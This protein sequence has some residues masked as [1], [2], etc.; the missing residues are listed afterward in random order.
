VTTDKQRLNRTPLPDLNGLALGEPFENSNL[1]NPAIWG[2]YLVAP[3][4]ALILDKMKREITKEQQIYVDWLNSL[5]WSF[6]TTLTTKYDLN[7]KTGRRSAERFFGILS[8]LSDGCCKMF[9]VVEPFELR[10]GM[11]I[12]ALIHLPD[13]FHEPMYYQKVIDAWQITSGT[14]NRVKDENDL[15]V[16]QKKSR[17]DCKRYDEKIGAGGYCS[18]YITKSRCDYDMLTNPGGYGF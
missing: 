4:C 11:H 15:W 8:R 7:M 12:H 1:V 3:N 16:E 10:D 6:W 14:Y 2:C 17:I 13:Q 18:K 5:E 9:F